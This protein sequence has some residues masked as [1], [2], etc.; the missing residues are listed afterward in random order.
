MIVFE[1]DDRSHH[2]QVCNRRLNLENVY[3]IT[4]VTK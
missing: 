3:S 1:I 2:T 4:N